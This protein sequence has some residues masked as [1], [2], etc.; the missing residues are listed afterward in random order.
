[1]ARLEPESRFSSSKMKQWHLELCQD[2]Q[3]ACSGAGGPTWEERPESPEADGVMRPQLCFPTVRENKAKITASPRLPST[4]NSWRC[5]TGPQKPQQR[6]PS[7]AKCIYLR[8]LRTQ[9]SSTC[10]MVSCDQEQSL[11]GNKMVT[12]A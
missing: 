6:S 7:L 10:L 2:G 11:P 1:M 9:S 5:P 4:S 12:L 8:L 3:L